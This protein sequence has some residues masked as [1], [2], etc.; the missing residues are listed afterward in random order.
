MSDPTNPAPSSPGDRVSS[1]AS[2]ELGTVKAVTDRY[3][4]VTADADGENLI[5]PATDFE[6]IADRD[7]I[8]E[9]EAQRRAVADIAA[10]KL[11][12]RSEL[13]ENAEGHAVGVYAQIAIAVDRCGWSLPELADMSGLGLG[14]L[15]AVLDGDGELTVT[16]LLLLAGALGADVAA[17]F[18]PADNQEATR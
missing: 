8:A 10:A 6:R 4:V 14:H 15:S 9:R 7:A 17:W 5:G 1:R 18:V 12:N 11:A 13:A 16:E 3:I 2:G